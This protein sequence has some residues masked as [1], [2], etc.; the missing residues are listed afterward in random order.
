MPA[1]VYKALTA[2]GRDVSGELE[3]ADRAGALRELSERGSCVTD[4]REKGSSASDFLQIGRGRGGP[5]LGN[6]QI[7]IFT[8]QLAISL[9]AGLPLMNSLSVISK[10][11]DQPA[12][13]QLLQDLAEK[14]QQGA[15]F[16]DA[17]ADYP[18]V[19]SPMYIRLVRVGETGG[20]LDT[21]LTQ[22]ADMLER[23]NEL[24]DRVRTASIYP[25]IL[26]G[27][28][29]LS[30]VVIVTLIVPRIVESIG[31]DP[32]LLPWPTR[33]LMGVSGFII[34]HWLIMLIMIVAAVLGWKHGVLRGPG[35]EHYDRLKLRLPILGR[36][37]RQLEAARFARSLGILT[38]GGVSIT[39]ALAVSKD[40]VQNSIVRQALHELAESVQ[41]GESIARLLQRSALFPPLLIQMVRVGENTG[42]LDEMLLRSA[43]V[44]ES[45]AR[46]AMDRFVSIL[47]VAMIL[48]LAVI[49]G[50]IVAG[51][52]LAIMEFQTAGFGGL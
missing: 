32:A 19:F 39:E 3:A 33:V 52:V 17:L 49:V 11:L 7:A 4:I 50:F 38:R 29:V 5:R 8:R 2:D 40:T 47:P 14:V 12:A 18:Q 31:A 30:V 22:L 1:F 25:A 20:M 26:L 42:K 23:Q 46:V 27:V 41:S 9:E 51:V 45:E 24:R 13:R 37:I 16:S 44:H 6:K 15:G 34:Q 36:L 28:G 10:E 48:V 35:R 21:V 43:G